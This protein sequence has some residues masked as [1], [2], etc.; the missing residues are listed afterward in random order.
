MDWK[1]ASEALSSAQDLEVKGR[2]EGLGLTA[3]GP[4]PGMAGINGRIDGS[5]KG[6]SVQL[7]GQRAAVEL[8]TVFADPKLDVEAFAADLAWTSG[9]DGTAGQDQRGHLP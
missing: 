9:A 3:L 5:E 1:G 8:P 4:V 2:F 7:N 6:G